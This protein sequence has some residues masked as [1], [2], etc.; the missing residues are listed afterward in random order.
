M[1][2]CQSNMTARA[3][4]KASRPDTVPVPLQQRLFARLRED[5][6]AGRLRPG[7][8]VPATRVLASDLSVSR[9][10]AVLAYEQLQAEGYI[11]TR[12]GAGTFVSRQLPEETL[13]A[14][15]NTALGTPRRVPRVG[16]ERGLSRCG[17]RMSALG[18]L[19]VDAAERYAAMP[20]DFRPGRP[21]W[22]AFPHQTWSRL[23]AR[24]WRQH[25]ADLASYGDPAGYRP[26]REAIARHLALTRGV[27]CHADQL[28]VV[29]GSQQ[30]ID[31]LL[32]L[33]L[34][35]GDV[36]ALEEPG[37]RGAALALR[38]HGVR[39]QPVC[40]DDD[41]LN[42]ATLPAPSSADAPR[43]V[44]V[45]PSHQ[46]P[47]GATLS[48]PRRLRLLEWAAQAGA[49]VVEDDYDSDFRYSGR[50]L[51]S[52]Q[53]LDSNGVAAYVGSFSKA[54][55]PPLRVGYVVVPPGL[56]RAFVAAKWLA[57]RQTATPD[58][59]VLSDFIEEG[60]FERH[61]RRMRRLYQGRRDT[62]LAALDEHLGGIVTPGGD[63]AGLHLVA[64][65]PSQWDADALAR[66]A[67]GLGV[68]TS[69]LTPYYEAGGG[70][71]ALMLGFAA[72]DETRIVEGIKRLAR[73]ARSA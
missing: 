14:P 17:A 58:Q 5:I 65:L 28:V 19:S 69:P 29:N 67:A 71:P 24:R 51:E 27:R 53:G 33:W 20:F 9:T 47:T 43:L 62:L 45:T 41:G 2:D 7:D 50:P 13:R 63:G 6:L 61:L 3:A 32:R 57:D 60:H 1:P 31:L 35:D 68:A 73:A 4:E 48:L 25:S 52:L 11:E 70:R 49:L 10:T 23:A 64:W 56:E 66:R 46:F 54:L 42:V 8:K 12:Q 15:K 21:D 16:R 26:L 36:A 18:E 38:A 44:Y 40:V 72:L 37:Y 59:Q 22:G 39:I 34:E 55:F 30:G